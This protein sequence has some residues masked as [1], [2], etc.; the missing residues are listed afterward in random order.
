MNNIGAY[1]IKSLEKYKGM[2]LALYVVYDDE[3]NVSP[4]KVQKLV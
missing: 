1:S 3:G 2:I 4:E